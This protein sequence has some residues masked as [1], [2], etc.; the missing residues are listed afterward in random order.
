MR[1]WAPAADAVALV[2]GGEERPLEREPGG[3]WRGPG[4]PPA[5]T[6]PSGWTAR[7]RSPT[8]ARPGSRR[9]STAPRARWTTG[10]FPGATTA[11]AA[12]HLPSAVIY[13][14]HVGTFTPEGT[15]DAAIGRLDDLVELGI[16]PVELMPVN[17]FPGGHG[18]GYD[19]VD[20]FAPHEPTAAPTG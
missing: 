10:P 1:V 9:A 5:P 18:W 4:L 3:W 19:G 12:S 20:L 16:T 11:G 7:G 2:S 14:L 13:E 6:T 17:A 15:F 8:P